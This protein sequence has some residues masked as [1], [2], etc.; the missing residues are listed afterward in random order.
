MLFVL[1][2][3]VAAHAA[4]AADRFVPADPHFVV[5]NVRQSTPDT[6]LR[7]LIER[8]RAAPGDAASAALA[9]AFLERAHALREPMYFGRAESVLAA[10]AGR[11]GASSEVRRLWAETLQY[12]HEFS[13][14]EQQGFCP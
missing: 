13:S 3:A 8:W 1:A 14:A 11:A 9:R 6:E 5:A 2:V 10:T 7:G 12:R 4:T